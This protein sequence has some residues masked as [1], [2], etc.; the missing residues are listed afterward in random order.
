[1]AKSVPDALR[2]LAALYEGR[3]A[4]YGDN[5]KWFGNA[6]AGLFPDGLHLKTV[7]DWNRIGVLI[8]VVAKLTR[9]TNQWSAGGH[10]DSLDDMAVYAQMLQELDSEIKE[11]ADFENS[12]FGSANAK[13][14]EL[15]RPGWPIAD[16]SDG[17]KQ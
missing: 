9:Y 10:K 7:E 6:M 11:S 15:L 17:A 14:E 1:M 4:L 12:L 8:Q 13:R 16:G 2:G 5:Y 3:N